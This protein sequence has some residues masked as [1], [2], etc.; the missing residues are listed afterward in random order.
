M[1]L[2]RWLLAVPAVLLVALLQ[3]Y[4]WV[5]TYDQQSAGNPKRLLK[6]IEASAADA[7]ILN[8]ILNADTVS[9]GIT[10]YVFEGLLGADEDLRL[11]GRLATDWAITEQAYLIVRPDKRLPD[12][13]PVSAAELKKRILDARDRSDRHGLKG[14]LLAIAVLHPETRAETVVTPPAEG[15]PPEIR[16]KVR[17]PE[18]LQFSLSRVD[19]DF[20]TRLEP[21]LGSGYLDG[22]PHERHVDAEEPGA[23]DRLR[24]HLA[25]L[26]PIAEHN[27]V[28]VFHLRRG[29]RFHDGTE[30][31]ARDVKFTYDAIMDPK[32]LSPRVSDFEPIKLLEIPDP[33]SVKITYKRLHSPA[34]NAWTMGIL[35]QHLLS[36]EALKAE[37]E[38]LSAAARAA[39]GLR[40]SRF[41]R[42]PVG[43]GPFKFVEWRGDEFI[44]LERNDDY[45]EGRPEFEDYYLRI[46]P[47]PLTQEV[48]FRTGAVDYY[49]AMP[50]QVARYL[51]D[52][53]YQSFSSLA[54]SYSYIGYNL[55]K[56][57]FADPRV[58]RALGMAIDV[59]DIIRYL[60]Y[61]EG[62]RTT[63]PFP[64]E[65]PWYDPAVHSLPYDP[66]AAL[67]LLEEAGW[68][69][70]KEGLLEK[71][72]TVFEFN[73]IT[74]SGNPARKNIMTIAQNAWK[75]IGI[76]C[77]T[78][79]FEWAVFL[80]D[81]VDKGAFDAVVLGWTTP[82]L[83]PDL[84]Q[85]FHSSQS[86]PKQLNFVA[87]NNP[88]ADRLILR[89][90]QEYD[91]ER[92]R[93]LAHRLHRIIGEDQPYNF[94]Y[95]PRATRVLDKK[96]VI[97]ERD[98][99]GQERYVK[100]YPTKGG[101]ISYY[102]NKWRKLA[103]TPEF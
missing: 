55:R 37:T 103:F 80:E 46:I 45:W 14:L 81:F 42:Y 44:H 26:L 4:F 5:P 96:I 98:A 90:R 10:D 23:A 22:F 6:Y 39:F 20:F 76:K 17:V 85:I 21:I 48:E 89:I 88:E 100:I 77:N 30:V 18:R 102:F 87:Y 49:G 93:A 97:V 25:E 50:H 99:R 38:N 24:A 19:Q 86:G 41:N 36:A 54:L 57:L 32:N 8:P 67:R 79:Y 63:G 27:P 7:K 31:T 3:A 34:I 16:V 82:P 13:T 70:N 56:P 71:D 28:I 83:D 2:R 101:T 78:Q 69:K 72:G 94:L 47:D 12:G 65:T 40:E 61:G 59:D 1:A 58:R 53:S 92:Q 29:V 15:K 95:T 60:L 51:K 62:E 66:A 52:D 35:P 64:K 84:Y 43:S 68:R 73:L 11:R 9:S 75:R 74:N 33:H 91:P